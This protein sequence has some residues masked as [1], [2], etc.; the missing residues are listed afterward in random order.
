MVK[1]AE[2]LTIKAGSEVIDAWREA[3]DKVFVGLFANIRQTPS[4][5]LRAD[6]NIIFWSEYHV[7]LK[8]TV[9]GDWMYP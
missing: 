8:I 3:M 4:I 2:K 9:G 5:S 7:V 1:A 6:R